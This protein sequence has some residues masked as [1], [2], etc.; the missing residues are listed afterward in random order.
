[1]RKN[2]KIFISIFIGCLFMS[3]SICAQ[4]AKKLSKEEIDS[5][6]DSLDLCLR[7]IKVLKEEK[8]AIENLKKN[9]EAEIQKSNSKK[10]KTAEPLLADLEYR[11]IGPLKWANKNLDEKQVKLIIESIVEAQDSAMWEKCA[12][13]TPAYCYHKEDVDKK[14]GV[15]LNIPALRLLSQSQKLKESNWRLPL[16]ADFDS[17]TKILLSTKQTNTISLL[18]NSSNASKPQWKKP[19]MDLFDMHIAP[20]SFR[21][22]NAKQWYGGDAA[23]FFCY[24]PAYENLNDILL[25]AEINDSEKNRIVLREQDLMDKYN[26]FGVFVRLIR[27]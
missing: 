21:L 4:K 3:Q 17:V 26:N 6:V 22:N 20:L 19:G 1:M 9:L 8:S 14:Y 11:N 12:L 13:E 18:I 27:K 2:F 23:S 24:E 16:Q 15:L 25:I 10:N 5:K 7:Q